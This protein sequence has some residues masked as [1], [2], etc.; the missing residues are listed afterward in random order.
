M[1]ILIPDSLT[2]LLLRKGSFFDR[3]DIELFEAATSDEVLKI[4]YAEKLD[5]L[6]IRLDMPGM[7]TEDLFSEIRNSQ[8]LRSV[9]SILVCRDRLTDRQRCSSCGA[10]AIF[11]LPVD[12]DLFQIKVQQLSN[13]APRK[14]Y[15]A[16]LAVA[17]QGKFRNKPSPFWTENISASGMLIRSGEPLAQGEGI[18]FSFFLSDGTH[19]AGYGEI[20]RVLQIT[21]F[22]TMYHYGIRFTNIAPEVLEAIKKT[23]GK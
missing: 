4:H 9:S 20:S 11:T 18:F 21:Q 16:I 10:N 17:I 7:R 6:I 8:Q 12:I 3:Y 22:P 13:I 23:V 19:V 1:K 15:R 14:S 5:L 2:E